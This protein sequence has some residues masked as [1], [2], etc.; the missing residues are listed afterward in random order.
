MEKNMNCEMRVVFAGLAV[1]FLLS[2]MSKIFAVIGLIATAFVA[3]TG[4]CMGA[5]ILGGAFCKKSVK[6]A[7]TNAG[8]EVKEAAEEVVDD[9]KDAV[10]KKKD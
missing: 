6:D 3:V 8:N 1:I 7:L 10:S 4:I 9:V 2:M 5:K